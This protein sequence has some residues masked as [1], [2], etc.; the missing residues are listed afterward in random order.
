V[1]DV[2]DF[3]GV[4]NMALLL[5]QRLPR[6]QFEH[7]I[8]Y[9]GLGPTQRQA[10]FTSA[11]QHFTAMPYRRG[12]WLSLFRRL[13]R[14]FLAQRITAVLCH[15]F[16]HHPWVGLAARAAGIR[17][18][19]TIV[20]SSP[21]VSRRAQLKN[22]IKAQ[23]GRPNCRLEIAVSPQVA[24]E[25]ERELGLPGRRIRTILNSC[26]TDEIAERAARRRSRRQPA[27]SILLM[28]ARL[29]AAKDHE[30]LLRAI[31]ELERRGRAV[32]LRLAGE[33]PLWGALTGLVRELGISP[34][35]EFLGARH[36]I[37]ELL[38]ESD[39]F[40]LA[41][42]TEGFGIVL[43][44]AMSASVPVISSDVPACRTVLEGGG[45][46]L[47][48]PPGNAHALADAITQLLDDTALRKRL[49][50]AGLERVRQHFDPQA[51]VDAYARLLKG[52]M[53]HLT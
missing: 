5:L 1:I 49:V 38:G 37:P 41:T 42:K 31:A 25:L 43:I 18:V 24:I 15:N 10:E 4:E 17:R 16:G 7:H 28:V 36:D 14:Y 11:S 3:G 6:D 40:I 19:Y 29:E 45:C 39:V 52:E 22:W 8:L 48:V 35:V 26:M 27:G 51:T 53:D 47:L 30:T 21:C 9:T 13:H 32:H 20:A 12:R 34:R 2:L 33:G 46:G 44:E 23:L 50:T